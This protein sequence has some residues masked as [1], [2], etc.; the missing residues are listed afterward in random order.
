MNCKSTVKSGT[1]VGMAVG[2]AVA[3]L[4]YVSHNCIS[5]A[6]RE[7]VAATKIIVNIWMN[8]ATSK[9]RVSTATNQQPVQLDHEFVPVLFRKVTISRSRRGLTCYMVTPPII[10]P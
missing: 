9:T 4:T 2:I 5:A 6:T 7:A 8:T 10:K 3:T 1:A